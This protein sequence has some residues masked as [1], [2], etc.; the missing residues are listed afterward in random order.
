MTN[1]PNYKEA[2]WNPNAEK[3]IRDFPCKVQEEIGTAFND[4]QHGAKPSC[5][6]TYKGQGNAKV[7]EVKCDYLTDTYRLVFTAEFPEFYYVAHA[8]MK[9]SP[10]DNE[11]PARNR[12]IIDDR[13]NGFRREYERARIAAKKEARN[14][15]KPKK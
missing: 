14:N 12:K 13:L 8:Y 10:R 11:V 1:P 2:L 4:F 7:K 9:K 5:I 15:P 3:E 6:E